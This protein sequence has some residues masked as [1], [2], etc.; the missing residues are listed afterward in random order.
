MLIRRSGPNDSIE[1]R[2]LEEACARVREG[3]C[4]LEDVAAMVDEVGAAAGEGRINPRIIKSFEA[5]LPKLLDEARDHE[6]GLISARLTADQLYAKLDQVKA[7][8]G[9]YRTE[10][11][12]LEQSLQSSLRRIGEKSTRVTNLINERSQYQETLRRKQE[13]NRTLLIFAA[14]GAFGAASTAV[15]L[16]S[17][18]SIG[19][20]QDKIAQLD[21][22]IAQANQEKT[23]IEAEK[24][25]F[26]SRQRTLQTKLEG[27]RSV[28]ATLDADL[29]GRPTELAGPEPRRVAQLSDEL[30]KNRQLAQNLKQQI[31]VL[32]EMNAQAG[33]F[34]AGLDQI[35]QSLEA[36]IE[37]LR[38]RNEA[39]ERELLGTVIDLT[40]AAAGIDPN[41]RIGDFSFSKKKL[42][43]E[44]TDYLRLSFHQQ[45][46]RLVD[47]MIEERLVDAV[48]SR[49]IANLLLSTLY[50]NTDTEAV[51]TAVR[52]HLT[53]EALRDATP[54]QRMLLTALLNR[55]PPDLGTLI[56]TVLRAN[57]NE[58]SAREAAA[59]LA[60][61]D[62]DAF[63]A[64]L[65]P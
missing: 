11:S 45:V 49:A 50:G 16:G 62:T 30:E 47:R 9:A 53:A 14:F 55:R 17:A 3:G 60:R 2:D 15:G 42:L 39:A 41:L 52:D 26:E 22:E 44:G 31:A 33:A 37:S 43:L 61:D 56:A 58:R 63:R 5:E 48:G 59:A 12:T 65:A 13:D 38:A 23:Q 24:R 10:I 40:F 36:E 35:I 27:L 6:P 46:N 32:R 34:E 19:Q 18:L 51:T 4:N 8:I 25:S 1:R 54:A 29:A 64:T 21:R 28:E 57:P 7:K 20:L